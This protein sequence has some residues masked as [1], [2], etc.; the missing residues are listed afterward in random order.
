MKKLLL[1]AAM[2]FSAAASA[3]TIQIRGSDTLGEAVRAAITNQ[4]LDADIQYI[5][6]GSGFAASDLAAKTQFIGPMSRLMKQAETDAL[7]A[8]GVEVKKFTIGLDGLSIFVNSNNTLR[9]LTKRDVAELFAAVGENEACKYTMWEQVPNS[10]M[11][12]P[13][14]LYRRDDVSGTTSSFKDMTGVKE[15]GS[16]VEVVASTAD[17][18]EKTEQ[19]VGA[20]AY[21]GRGAKRDGNREVPIL[22]ETDNTYYLPT[23]DNVRQLKYP[24][25]R[26]LYVYYS[27]NHALRDAEQIL[28]D[29]IKDRDSFD[30][31]LG[32]VGLV[33]LP[34][35]FKQEE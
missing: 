9:D 4:A 14:K 29:F 18:A 1:F 30:Q 31:I 20:I 7:V 13:I 15:F 2:A 32:E 5:G 8:A 16:C 10:G 35:G 17:I 19:E 3:Q 6:G 26:Y 21:G 23:D 24:F 33:T 27:T 25:S 34:E 12:G 28:L 11:T 22:N